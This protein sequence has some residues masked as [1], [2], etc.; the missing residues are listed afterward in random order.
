VTTS[1]YTLSEPCPGCGRN[2]TRVIGGPGTAGGPQY[3]AGCDYCAWR[4]WGDT[5][6]EAIAEWN[7]RSL[8]HAPATSEEHVEAVARAIATADKQPGFAKM[9]R[10]ALQ[11]TSYW[12]LAKAALSIPHPAEA[13]LVEV[14]AWLRNL[15][16][17]HAGG[18]SVPKSALIAIADLIARKALAPPSPREEAPPT[19]SAGDP[20]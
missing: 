17:I 20:E 1:P 11:L 14:L 2:S 7:T 12:D 8:P 15:P 5:E 10:H 9:H 16:S 3:W 6:A 4:T 18:V 19:D 13:Q